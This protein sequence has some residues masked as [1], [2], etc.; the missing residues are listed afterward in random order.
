MWKKATWRKGK[1]RITGRWIYNW[2]ADRF[3]VLL[4][5]KDPGTGLKREPFI[6]SGDSPEFGGWKLVRPRTK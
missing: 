5:G 2:H 6:V 3:T 1:R 4:N